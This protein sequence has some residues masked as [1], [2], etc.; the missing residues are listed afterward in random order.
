MMPEA[1][2]KQIYTAI[3]ADLLKRLPALEA[4][5]A[6][7]DAAEVRHIGHAIKGGCGM[8]GAQQASRIGALLQAEELD[9]SVGPG[10]NHLDDSA[11]LLSDLR[12]A[13]RNLESMLVREFPA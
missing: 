13:A 2:V 7:G 11:R 4:A 10:R 12:A 9:S 3:V 8:A 1:A 6:K 5:I